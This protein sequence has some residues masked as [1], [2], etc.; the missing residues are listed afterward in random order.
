M[1]YL[2]LLLKYHSLI[3][4]VLKS[5]EEMIPDDTKVAGAQKLDM[6]LKSIIQL[7]STLAGKEDDLKA[8]F[9]AAKTIYNAVRAALPAKA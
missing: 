4:V 6:A 2:A 1:S 3:L 5:V 7:D 8:A 9:S